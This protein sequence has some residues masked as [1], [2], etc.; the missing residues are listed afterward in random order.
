MMFERIVDALLAFTFMYPL[1]MAYLWMFGGIY[2]RLQWEKHDGD[3]WQHPK[4]LPFYP[5]V[6]VMLPCHNEGDLVVETLSF[7]LNLDYP[8]YDVIAINDGSTDNTGEILDEQ[9]KLHDKLRVIHL[10]TNQGKAMGLNTAALM[11]DSE[12]LVCI[13]GDA[14]LD[15]NAL[16]WLMTHFIDSP[17][18]GAVTGNPRIRNRSSLLGKIQVGEFSCIIGMI[19]RAQRIYG[20]VFTVSGVVVAFRKAALQRIGYWSPDM[21][22][23]DIDVSWR[24]QLAH[25]DVRYEPNALCWILMPETLKGLYRQRTRW[26]QGGAETWLRYLPK[27]MHWKKRRFWLVALEYITSVIWSYTL[28][29]IALLWLLGKIVPLP[30]YLYIKTLLPGWTGVILGF[31]CLLQFLVSLIIDSRYERGIT[32]NYYWMIWYP[33]A[34]WMLNVITTV[35]GFPKAIFKKKGQ[36]AVWKSPDRGLQSLDN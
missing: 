10:A 13:D 18:V 6:T 2:Y 24:L 15:R 34:Y 36:R 23:E 25:W 33:L 28:T 31:T 26:A 19:K 3:D 16:H 8:N 22:T 7:L 20:R 17:R 11:T 30:D 9:V 5:H 4:P 21:I 1:L 29:A 32:R 12:F 14:L 27:M 35:V